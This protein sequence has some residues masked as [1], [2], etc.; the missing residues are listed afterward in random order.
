[1]AG[2]AITATAATAAASR[3]QRNLGQEQRGYQAEHHQPSANR[4]HVLEAALAARPAEEAVL[5]ALRHAVEHVAQQLESLRPQL[6]RRSTLIR[7]T[8]ALLARGVRLQ[9]ELRGLLTQF[10]A[11]RLGVDPQIDLRPHIAAAWA[12]AGLVAAR[13]LWER[14]GQRREL[15]SLLA[16]AYHLLSG[17]LAG[18]L[19]PSS[20]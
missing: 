9:E 15:S 1:V 16:E 5:D 18:A 11:T 20:Y 13:E 8:P 14:G 6:S 12:M 17:D 3:A 10:A 2:S 19:A 7:T 4:E